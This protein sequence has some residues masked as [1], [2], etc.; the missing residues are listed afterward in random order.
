MKP[1]DVLKKT[2]H[3]LDNLKKAKQLKVKVGLPKETASG[4]VYDNGVT[5]IQ[6]GIW[7]EF[8]NKNIPM[9]SFIRAPFVEKR[10]EINA[11][12]STQFEAVF[13]RGE[14]A[15][16]ALNKVGVKA[17]SICKGAFRSQGYGQWTAN[18]PA[19]IKA[20]GSSMALIDTGLLRNSITWALEG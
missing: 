3:Y 5:V 14:D 12:I 2:T 20:K 13:D 11:Y 16:T 9:R 6:V 17:M 4:K 1:E 8:G 15:E 19:T 10:E 7:H 18:K